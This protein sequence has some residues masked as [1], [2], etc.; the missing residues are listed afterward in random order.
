[1]PRRHAILHEPLMP[2]TTIK[3][4]LNS[5]R[6]GTPLSDKSIGEMSSPESG[7]VE[8]RDFAVPG[9]RL[10]IKSTG[11]KSFVLRKRVGKHVRAIQIGHFNSDDFLLKDARAKALAILSSIDNGRGEPLSIANGETMS[12]AFERYRI[13]KSGMRSSKEIERIFRRDILPALSGRLPQYISRSEITALIDRVES[14]SMGRAVAAQLSAFFNWLMPRCDDLKTNPCRFAGKPRKNPARCRVL[15]N[16]ELEA[17]WHVL[18]QEKSVFATGIKLLMVTLQR[19]GEVFGADCSEFDLEGSRWTIPLNRTKNGRAHEV[20]LS[21]LAVELVRRQMGG[22]TKGKLFP[23]RGNP[24]GS[25]SGFSKA[26]ARIRQGV[27]EALGKQVDRFTMHDIRRTGATGLQRLGVRTEV[28]E[29]L[30]N[31][32]SGTQSGIVGIYQRYDFSLE[33]RE[34]MQDWSKEVCR[35]VRSAVRR[36]RENPESV[37]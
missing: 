24:K 35:I 34:A 8:L 27:D 6:D 10:R 22:R 13:A 36:S 18:M 4:G 20:P 21:T 3:I 7:H 12:E 1:M 19:R 23:A 32:V 11:V 26:W 14:P 30:L 28:T 33:K 31:H 25:A 9:L 15:T 2:T 17:L 5:T 16:H 29:R 37:P